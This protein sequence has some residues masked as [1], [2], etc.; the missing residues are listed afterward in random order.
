MHSVKQ[1]T[2]RIGVVLYISRL[3][4]QIPREATMHS[5]AGPVANM[6]NTSL[7]LASTGGIQL[8]YE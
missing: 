7:S 5:K 8:F 3:N 1:K 6:A 4:D 2:F